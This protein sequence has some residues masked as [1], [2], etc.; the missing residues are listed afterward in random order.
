MANKIAP[1][2]NKKK[3]KFVI[4]GFTV[5]VMLLAFLTLF[6]FSP[7]PQ[8]FMSYVPDH[9]VR[10]LFKDAIQTITLEDEQKELNE[11][12]KYTHTTNLPVLSRNTGLCFRF[13]STISNENK[14]AIDAK[15][16]KSA[17]YNGKPIAEIIVIGDNKK[18]YTLSGVTVTVEQT[19]NK[20]EVS[21][22]CQNFDNTYSTYPEEITAVY[23]RPLRPFT[24]SAI[25]WS[26]AI[27]LR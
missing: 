7:L 27:E 4:G 24:P 13:N 1:N 23:V 12:Q 19:D 10:E 22:L 17:K 16:L 18:E 5:F 26:T 15:R 6:I 2:E 9:M 25:T 8:I 11:P 14:N 21:Y 3:P 20:K